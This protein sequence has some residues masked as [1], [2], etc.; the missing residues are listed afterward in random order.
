[1]Y[2]VYGERDDGTVR[3]WGRYWTLYDAQVETADPRKRGF[4][5]RVWI[6]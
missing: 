3:L 1:M 4:F 5:R 6:Q 2:E